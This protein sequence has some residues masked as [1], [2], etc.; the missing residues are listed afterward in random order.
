M[1]TRL[2]F[3]T[4]ILFFTTLAG[5]ESVVIQSVSGKVEVQ[6]PGASWQKAS[7][8][9]E[10]PL[11]TQISTGFGSEAK[12]EMDNATITVKPLTRMTIQELVTTESTATT[13]LFLGAGRIR[14]DVRRSG[15]LVNDFQVRSPVA[16]AAVRGTS[17]TFDGL[18]LEVLEGNVDFSGSKGQKVS[19]PAGGKSE[20]SEGEGPSDPS[21]TK[22]E[23]TSVSPT[24]TSGEDN[25][26]GD[27]GDDELSSS[28]E[29][30]SSSATTDLYGTLEI[31]IE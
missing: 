14:A 23:E 15:S 18:R 3:I 17:F 6:E 2:C 31:I 25:G 21:D 1:H 12:V 30:G 28:R 27:T 16:T 24:T 20:T 11:N 13:K 22:R 29:D 10:L 9:M 19:V 26:Q 7:N 4:I 5:A 8:G